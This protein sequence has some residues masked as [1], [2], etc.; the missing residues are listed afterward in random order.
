MSKFGEKYQGGNVVEVFTSQGK[1][2]FQSTS[3][4]SLSIAESW[5]CSH[6]QFAKKEFVKELK[7]VCRPNPTIFIRE[8]KIT[9]L[10][11]LNLVIDMGSLVSENFRDQTFR[12]LDKI[13]IHGSFR[14]RKVFTA[15]SQPSDNDNMSYVPLPQIVQFP[16]GVEYVT[17]LVNLRK[18]NSLMLTKVNDRQSN[19]QPSTKTQSL[20]NVAFGRRIETKLLPPGSNAGRV[21][22]S[23]S[24]I[25]TNT[26]KSMKDPD[27]NTNGKNSPIRSTRKDPVVPPIP[28]KSL[29][30]IQNLSSE[31]PAMENKL[32]ILPPISQK[33]IDDNGTYDPSKYMDNTAIP[34]EEDML[35]N[36]SDFEGDVDQW[37]TE[38]SL[39]EVDFKIHPRGNRDKSESNNQK[40]LDD[41]DGV[42]RLQ[43]EIDE[44]LVSRQN[45]VSVVPKIQDN[46][47]TANSHVESNQLKETDKNVAEMIENI[48]D[49]IQDSDLSTNINSENF[50][51]EVHV[52]NINSK[53]YSGRST[54]VQK[55]YSYD[56]I[57]H[58][59]QNRQ[60][61]L[62]SE[63]TQDVVLS[64]AKSS[65]LS[66]KSQVESAEEKEVL[67]KL[68]NALET[69]REM[70]KDN[71]NDSLSLQSSRPVSP[72]DLLGE[73]ILSIVSSLSED[74]MSHTQKTHSRNLSSQSLIAVAAESNTASKA[75]SGIHVE[76]SKVTH[77]S[78][79]IH[80]KPTILSDLKILNLKEKYHNRF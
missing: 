43:K 55:H 26:I 30:P 49:K 47:Q 44:F 32:V 41:V 64:P 24:S 63:E 5:K 13:G 66:K 9:A 59:S 36:N 35:P 71:D 56:N 34:K 77:D 79:N 40:L 45:T 70:N 27:L 22:T 12:S 46:Y 29:K 28:Q 67:E 2:P 76:S 33:N 74:E 52:T 50:D 18:M 15:K 23:P 48:I 31:I 7:G 62:F 51:F 57:E 54:P 25:V 10:H 17:E 4:F 3:N 78:I 60:N 75:Q 38:S 58:K 37:E 14:L 21:S 65:L 69:L 61:S 80:M 20:N 16:I 6:K 8:V 73:K 72:F 11:W 42:A 53:L 19:I 1:S 68:A 39:E